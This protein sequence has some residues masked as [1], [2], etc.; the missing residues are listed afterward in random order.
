METEK[1]IIL[2]DGVC[3]FC[4][5][6]VDFVIARD[7]KGIFRLGALQSEEAKPYL[8][9]YEIDPDD[10]S[11]MALIEDGKLYR[12]STAALRIARRLKQPWPLLYV[13]IVI[14]PFVRDFVY[15]WIAKNRYK[16]FGKMESCRMPTDELRERFLS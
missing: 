10:L 7:P 5:S 4:N 3:N 6:S 13:F 2:F 9:K 15:N 12:R 16:W 11:S 1:P 8:E 14:P